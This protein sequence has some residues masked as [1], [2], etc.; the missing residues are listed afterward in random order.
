MGKDE[1]TAGKA[2]KNA[3]RIRKSRLELHEN[4]LTK[5]TRLFIFI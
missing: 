2:A 4:V 5:G 3:E 1:K